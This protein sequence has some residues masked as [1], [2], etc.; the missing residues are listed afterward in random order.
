MVLQFEKEEIK[1]ASRV[2]RKHIREKGKQPTSIQIKDKTGKV[3]T[4][5]RTEYCGL[6]DNMAS[7]WF[8]NGKLPKYTSLLYETPTAYRGNPQPNSWTCGSTSLANASTQVFQ[9]VSEKECRDACQTNKNGTLPKNLI[10]GGKKLGFE[11][12]RIDRTFTAVKKAIDGGCGVIAHIETGGNTKPQCLG[13]V[14]NYGH[15]IN[16]YN[17]TS[18][19]QFKVYDPTKGYHTCNAQQIIKATNGRDIGFYSVKALN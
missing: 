5:K 10:I 9:Y 8:K 16:I 1:K 19:Y 15:Y 11:V 17:Y 7:Y 18:A 12:K 6:F 14:S 4:L 3:R 2:I 13:F